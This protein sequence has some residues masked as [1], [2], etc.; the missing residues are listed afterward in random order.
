[1]KLAEIKG[2]SRDFLRG[3]ASVVRMLYAHKCR[4]VRVTFTLVRLR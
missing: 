3:D 4:P 1:M 2:F